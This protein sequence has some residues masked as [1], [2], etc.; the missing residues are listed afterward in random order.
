MADEPVSA[1]D[2]SVQAQI[3]NLFKDLQEEE[4]LTLLFVSHDKDVLNF[5][6]DRIV[7]IKEGK[8]L[9]L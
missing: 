1:L 4:K 9:S 6:C 5:M 7:E 2:P 3:L 8:V